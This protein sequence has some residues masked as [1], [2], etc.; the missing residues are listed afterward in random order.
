M[1]SDVKRQVLL[2]WTLFHISGTQRIEGEVEIDVTAGTI[3]KTAKEKVS[4][5]IWNH[6]IAQ[7]KRM[8]GDRLQMNSCLKYDGSL[9]VIQPEDAVVRWL[10]E[11]FNGKDTGFPV[12]W[13]QDKPAND[14]Q[15]DHTM[16]LL[17]VPA[18]VRVF[19][20]LDSDGTP[21]FRFEIM[22]YCVVYEMHNLKNF[23]SFKD[24]V[25]KVPTGEIRREQFVEEC[26]R[27]EYKALA[28]TCDF[29]ANVWKPW[30]DSHRIPTDRAVWKSRW[31][32]SFETWI[33]HMRALGKG[34]PD[35]VF[36][37]LF[38]WAKNEYGPYFR[39]LLEAQ[40]TSPVPQLKTSK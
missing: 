32:P 6:G 8:L 22:W 4:R 21:T 19:E 18:S 40:K 7:T 33:K 23:L 35:K 15:A 17:G 37:N 14:A 31:N 12:F 2:L 9:L 1:K 13:D 10:V 24:L 39:N 25:Q 20:P 26:A 3:I 36:N 27:L 30:A 34:Y 38:D 29:H 5:I 11:Q 16:P 28:E